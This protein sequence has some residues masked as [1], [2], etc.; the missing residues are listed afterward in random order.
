ML[1][2]IEQFDMKRNVVNLGQLCGGLNIS[3][4]DI[5]GPKPNLK[6]MDLGVKSLE[7]EQGTS[8]PADGTV[9]ESLFGVQVKIGQRS[10]E[11]MTYFA[12]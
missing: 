9:K 5:A 11:Q 3:A 1:Q 7:N 2:A 6:K 8:H 10:Q 4:S 12:D